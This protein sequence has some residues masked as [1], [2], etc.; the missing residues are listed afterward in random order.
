M[1]KDRE[2]RIETDSYRQKGRTDRGKQRERG[3]TR[4]ETHQKGN[5]RREKKERVETR[6]KMIK[7]N[8]SHRIV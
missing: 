2:R 3:K 8:L 7:S 1:N 6:N 4:K 5:K